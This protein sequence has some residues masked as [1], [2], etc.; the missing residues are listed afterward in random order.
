[1]ISPL[2]AILTKKKQTF[3]EIQEGNRKFLKH[4][5][6]YKIFLVF[7][8]S[9][10]ICYNH[11]A[12]IP[13]SNSIY[14]LQI[15]FPLYYDLIMSEAGTVIVSLVSSNITSFLLITTFRKLNYLH[16]SKS[17]IIGPFGF[18]VMTILVH[19]SAFSL[20]N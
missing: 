18:N 13:C 20:S 10:K 2:L 12:K 17:T 9:A 4:K 19:T 6:K 14:N 8:I 16:R 15:Y 11:I 3:S 7:E 5:D 1:M